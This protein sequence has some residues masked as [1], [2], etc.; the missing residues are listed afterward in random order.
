MIYTAEY[1][2]ERRKERWNSSNDIDFDKRFRNA[3][4]QRLL[5]DRTLLEEIKVKPEKL[6]ELLFI[7]VDKEQNTVPFFLNE[8]Q[9]DFINKLNKAIE[10]YEKGLILDIG[11]II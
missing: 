2:I 4:A 11:F 9:K 5:E 3:T 6:I 8:V 7:V 1:L 10:D